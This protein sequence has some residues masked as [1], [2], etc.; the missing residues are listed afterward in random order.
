MLSN[1]WV[2]YKHNNNP[3]FFPILFT[4]EVIYCCSRTGIFVTQ[5]FYHR[6]ESIYTH[7]YQCSQLVF[8]NVVLSLLGTEASSTASARNPVLVWLIDSSAGK[9]VLV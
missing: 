5:H 7:F 2:S 3:E 6:R 1:V 9:C 8:A 4:L